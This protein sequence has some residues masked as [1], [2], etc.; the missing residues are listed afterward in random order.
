MHMK[1]HYLFFLLRGSV[2]G[3]VIVLFVLGFLLVDDKALG[4]SDSFLPH[5]VIVELL[6]MPLMRRRFR[7]EL[8]RS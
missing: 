7:A 4:I 1:M 8:S 5:K 2:I 3:L 6:K